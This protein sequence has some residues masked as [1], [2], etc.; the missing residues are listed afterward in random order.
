MIYIL[1]N[2]QKKKVRQSEPTFFD[3]FLIFASITILILFILLI[4]LTT[5]SELFLVAVGFL[6]TIIYV[7]TII[8]LIEDKSHNRYIVWLLPLILSTLFYI[9]TN[10]FNT[11][12][13]TQM[14]TDDL[15]VLN[16]ILSYTFAAIL[17]FVGIFKYE[18]SQYLDKIGA[19]EKDKV[20]LEKELSALKNV[21]RV[22]RENLR[23]YMQG[24]EDKCKALNFVIGRV[25][26]DKNGG[27]KEMR[28]KLKINKELYNEFS[29]I[30]SNY[31]VAKKES[32]LLLTEKILNHLNTL[33]STEKDIFKEKCAKLKNIKRDSDSKSKIIEVLIKN[34]K[35][36][37]RTYFEGAMDN[38]LQLRWFFE[39]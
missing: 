20:D 36:P 17:S 35:D 31:T 19:L 29:K 30:M 9:I 18:E 38:C 28:E 22:T 1:N 14:K 11:A 33:F 24:I 5:H 37:V 13:F 6:P 12:L 15:T 10:I 32:A 26:S 7:I 4:G 16:L 2:M 34:D 27:D 21:K 39:K 8:S 25:Y 23:D 3:R